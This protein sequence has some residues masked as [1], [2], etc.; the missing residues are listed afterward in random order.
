MMI[1]VAIVSAPQ[2]SW[3]AD[4]WLSRYNFGVT[5]EANT[6][7][8][9]IGYEAKTLQ[10]MPE[11][12]D[13]AEN[14]SS[15]IHCTAY[16]APYGD[17]YP[18]PSLFL[19]SPFKRTG[20]F[21]FDF[22]FTFST[23]TYKGTLVGKPSSAVKSVGGAKNKTAPSQPL[24]K[25]LLELYGINWQSFLSLGITPRYLPDLILSA[26]VGLQTVGG[27]VKILQSDSFR[28]VVQ[29]EIF[30]TLELYLLR[31]NE[32]SFSMFVGRD[33]SLLSQ[34]GTRLI[35]DQTLADQQ[36][37]TNFRLGLMTA[38]A[39]LRILFPF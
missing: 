23:V 10:P 2:V 26:G 14:D 13:P 1:A 4:G 18:T 24:T 28:T 11:N 33:Q 38:S 39:G 9:Q 27:R 34:T 5:Y 30:G 29:P 22:G 3:A 16:L 20:L 7:Y 12:C 36:T 17:S 31:W 6:S 19:Q 21:Y 25:A 32:S 15:R 8:A 35:D 37:L